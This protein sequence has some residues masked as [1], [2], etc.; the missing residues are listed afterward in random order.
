MNSVV[1]FGGPLVHLEFLRCHFEK[2][3]DNTADF[4]K[5]EANQQ[6][7]DLGRCG[8]LVG[9]GVVVVGFI[10]KLRRRGRGWR[11]RSGGA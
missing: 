9:W 7:F 5:V 6:V 4:L 2:S 8:A 10:R 3:N 1:R 11:W